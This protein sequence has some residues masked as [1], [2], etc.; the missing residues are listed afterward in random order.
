[1]RTEGVVRGANYVVTHGGVLRTYT[2][3]EARADK[4]LQAAIKRNGWEQISGS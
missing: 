1:M 3:E 2:L 4:K